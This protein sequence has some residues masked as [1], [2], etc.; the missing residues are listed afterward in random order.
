M[1][2]RAV[3]RPGITPD[4]DKDTCPKCCNNAA[5]P[6]NNISEKR[7]QAEDTIRKLEQQDALNRLADDVAR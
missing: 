4:L 2:K 6:E 3:V 7:A 5:K 1:E